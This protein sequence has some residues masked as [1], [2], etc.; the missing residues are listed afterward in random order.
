M[1]ESGQIRQ[2]EVMDLA[3]DRFLVSCVRMENGFFLVHFLP[4]RYVA[5]PINQ[6][7]TPPNSHW[8]PYPAAS[9][10]PNLPASSRH[11]APCSR[12]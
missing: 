5:A 10:I 8:N 4:Y 2:S 1:I 9:E 7:Q 6:M 3:Q 12:R 11:S